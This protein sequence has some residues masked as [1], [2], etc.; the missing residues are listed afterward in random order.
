MISVDH[1][2][3]QGDKL[4]DDPGHACLLGQRHRVQRV[5][6]F[7]VISGESE[8]ASYTVITILLYTVITKNVICAVVTK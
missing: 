5:V 7:A 4:G 6:A 8:L 2:R 3:S 1:H